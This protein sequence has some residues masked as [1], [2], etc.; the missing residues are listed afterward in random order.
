M[1][2]FVSIASYRDP[3]LV[4][5]VRDC[6][7]K[8]R[9]P[10]RLRF[11]I[12]WQH[13][14][15]EVLPAWFG[16]DQFSVVDVDHR[17][18]RG[19]GWARARLNDLWGDAEWYLQLDS[20]HRFVPD[21]DVVL[22]DEM[23]LAA[24]DRPVLTTYAPPFALD[25]PLPSEP[26]PMSMV[27]RQFG[28]NGMPRFMPQP[29]PDW[30]QRTGPHRARFAS[31]HF[32][33]AQRQ[34]L[35]DV[36]YDPEIYFDG[37]EISLAVRAF[38]HGYDLFEPS[39]VLLWHEYSR[40]YRRKHWD[41]HVGDGTPAW[42]DLD[43]ETTQRVGRLLAEPEPGRYGLG[44]VRTL[45]DYEAYAG[46]SFR[47]RRVQDHTR[48]N[49]EPPNPPLAADWPQRV[50]RRRVALDIDL[51]ARSAAPRALTLHD[52][53]GG[54]LHRHAVGPADLPEPDRL[55]VDAIF[56]SHE[57]PA[58]WRLLLEDGAASLA[59]PVDPGAIQDPYAARPD[60]V[61]GL[62]WHAD[63]EGFVVTPPGSGEQVALNSSAAL[64]VERAD[65]SLSVRE[66]AADLT[67]EH[68]LER[69]PSGDLLDF[70]ENARSAGLVG[71]E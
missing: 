44:A 61:R 59:G 46:I 22:L 40:S 50:A 71:L 17:D 21:W 67:R 23:A 19:A 31:A 5:T 1:S 38:T 25:Q 10:E 30:Q 29:I 32:L 14:D 12:C 47:H 37:E 65:G 58:S 27:F 16:G 55:V 8:A 56:D 49:G 13:G 43:A 57:Q 11:G 51:G 41:D 35:R 68:G 45:E 15:D 39:R 52:A 53:D 20:H 6:L 54:E 3:Q 4:P 18:S 34:F 7:E 70:Y 28:A 60:R 24:S 9:H 33:F 2:V 48:R 69:D 64:L 26:Q 63:G 62:V 66:I 42:H 36:P